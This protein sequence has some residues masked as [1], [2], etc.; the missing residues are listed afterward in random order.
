VK[1]VYP[2]KFVTVEEAASDDDDW[3]EVPMQRQPTTCSII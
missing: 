2:E 3:K 1:A